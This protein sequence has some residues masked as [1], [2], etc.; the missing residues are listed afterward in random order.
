MKKVAIIIICTL[1]I[2][3]T[4]PVTG[5]VTMKIKK[6]NTVEVISPQLNNKWTKL[7]NLNFED[8]GSSVQQTPDGGYIIIGGTKEKSSPDRKYWD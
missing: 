5:Q 4:I 6:N 7:F 3:T 8:G 2:S 1:L